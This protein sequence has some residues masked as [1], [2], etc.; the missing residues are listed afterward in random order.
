[1]VSALN[2]ELFSDSADRLA[3]WPPALGIDE[4]EVGVSGSSRLCSTTQSQVSETFRS[5]FRSGRRKAGFRDFRA[6]TKVP[7]G[8]TETIPDNVQ[9]LRAGVSQLVEKL[10]PGCVADQLRIIGDVVPSGEPEQAALLAPIQ[11]EGLGSREARPG[12]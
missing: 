2:G 4:L 8:A 10:A 1:M 6:P 9:G 11:R 12:E 5:S 7:S 3:S